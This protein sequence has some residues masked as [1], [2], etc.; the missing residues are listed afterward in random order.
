MKTV[1]YRIQSIDAHQDEGFK[2]DSIRVT[3]DTKVTEEMCLRNEFG[4]YYLHNI[5]DN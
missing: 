5:P 1:Y 4:T 3:S 2:Y